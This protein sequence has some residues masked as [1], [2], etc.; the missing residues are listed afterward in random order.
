MPWAEITAV[1]YSRVARWT[2]NKQ[3]RLHITTTPEFLVCNHAT[4]RPRGS[5]QYN[6]F[7]PEERNA[8]VL[9]HLNGR[10][11]VTCKPAIPLGLYTELMRYLQLFRER[12]SEK[13][14]HATIPKGN[15]GYDQYT[16]PDYCSCR[17]YFCCFPLALGNTFP[18]PFVPILSD[19]FEKQRTQ[20]HPR[21]L[22]GLSRALFPTTFLEMAVIY[23]LH[24]ISGT[25]PSHY[26]HFSSSVF[27]WVWK[28][29]NHAH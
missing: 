29:L 5:V 10:R 20:N 7:S 1:P 24:V 14:V 15:M 2:L 18:W 19:F 9:D 11:D 3:Y 26:S 4:R 12:L 28:K 27:K 25:R 22:S 13:K 6:F 21:C 8:F 16:V 17:T 23:S